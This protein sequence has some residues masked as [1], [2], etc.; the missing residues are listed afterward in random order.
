MGSRLCRRLGVLALAPATIAAAVFVAV[1][2]AQPSEAADLVSVPASGTW[3][4][5][6]HGNGHG[7]GLSQYGAQGA[8]LQGLDASQILA[9]YYPGTTPAALG[10][11]R[12]RVLISDSGTYLTVASQTGLNLT[13]TGTSIP[14]PSVGASQWR[15]IPSGAGFAAQYLSDTWHTW[16]TGL[17]AQTNFSSGGPVRL[18]HSDGTSNA[19]RGVL[20]AIRSG[21]GS[22]AVN[23]VALDDYTQGVVPR[24]SPSGWQPAALQAQAVAARSYGR[25]AVEHHASSQ[26]DICDT[27]SCQ[28]YG[29]YA[30]Y[31]AAGNRLYG[32]EA[33]TNAAVAA[34]ANRVLTYQGATIFAQFSAADG[35][36]TADGGQPYLIA[37]ADP[38][39]K[40]ANGPYYS[41]T[42]TVRAADVASYYGLATVTQIQITGRDGHGD[43]GGRVTTAVVRGTRAGGAAA[44]VTTTGPSLASAMGLPH[45]WFTFTGAGSSN[46]QPASQPSQPSQPGQ[47]A[48]PQSDGSE[49]IT[50]APIVGPVTPLR[51]V[52]LFD[53]STGF[54]ALTPSHILAY[55]VPGHGN[56]PASAQ[57][58]QLVVTVV[59][60]SSDGALKV[61]AHR[62]P[63]SSAT[64]AYRAGHDTSATVTIALDDSQHVDFAPT[65]GSVQLRAD[66]SGYTSATGSNVSVVE[67]RVLRDV[68]AVPTDSAGM[69]VAVIGHSG[70]PLSATAALLQVS[71]KSANGSSDSAV[72]VWPQGLADPGLAQVVSARDYGGA[73]VVLL[74]LTGDGT[75]RIAA[76]APGVSARVSVVGYVTAPGKQAPG[77][78]SGRLATLPPAALTKDPVKVS[79]TGT[80]VVA[81]S[82]AGLPLSGV[83]GLVLQT[84]CS[85]ASAAGELRV[86]GTGQPAPAAPSATFGPGSPTTSTVVSRMGAGATITLATNGPTAQCSVTVIG[87]ATVS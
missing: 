73:N 61:F 37:K 27:S 7:H 25:Y 31:D 21:A 85:N 23:N 87:Y 72:R 66:Q 2:T 15:L 44:S 4:V 62:S 50:S 83:H 32:E 79:A 19:Y 56:V 54:G 55:G 77:N 6:G 71:V 35:G 51:P 5:D 28:V 48:V 64:I 8:A 17:P 68:P 70:V 13:Y 43:W 41:W 29:G 58:V 40:F 38:Y 36:W 53:T 34:T 52:R 45:Q 47:P 11:S 76:S 42:R 33:S 9:F 82:V 18:F 69:L 86:Y 12:V 26:Y 3:T 24:E 75:I 67:S 65:S 30:R 20:S 16:R 49:P 14:L 59:S 60:P 57:A 10:P 81:H 22:I 78:F 63:D 39:E 84:T 80:S 1:L 46:S 74:P